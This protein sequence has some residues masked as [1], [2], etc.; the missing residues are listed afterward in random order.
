MKSSKNILS[1]L[2]QFFLEWEIFQ[3]KVAEK[4]KTHVLSKIIP[5]PKKKSCP[6]RDTEEKYDRVRQVTDDSTGSSKKM[7]G[8]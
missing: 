2:A 1:N 3:T 6:I 4:F 5:P 8:I 7:D